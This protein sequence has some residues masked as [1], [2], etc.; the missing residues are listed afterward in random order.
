MFYPESKE[1]GSR[2]LLELHDRDAKLLGLVGEVFLDTG[3]GEDKD[4]DREHIQHRVV[5]LEGHGLGVLGPV[6]LEGHLR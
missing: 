1:G 6:G 2:P 4:P 3:S 5:A